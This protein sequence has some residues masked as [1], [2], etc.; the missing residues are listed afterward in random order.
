MVYEQESAT[1]EGMVAAAFAELHESFNIDIASKVSSM[2]MEMLN[3]P[4]NKHKVD[5]MSDQIY[6]ISF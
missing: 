3:H 2:H 6:T 1:L 5:S 4:N